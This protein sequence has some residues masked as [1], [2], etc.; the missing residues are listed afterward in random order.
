MR[1]GFFT[2]ALLLGCGA[3]TQPPGGPARASGMLLMN[4]TFGSAAIGAYAQSNVEGDF[5]AR[6]T[7]NNGLTEGRAVIV[8]E[9]GNRFL[10][11]TYV[12]GAFGPDA[13]GV[14]F[15]VALGASYDE[16]YFAYRVRFAPGFTFMRGGKLPGLVG[17]T[18]PTGCVSDIS[19]FSAR[20]MWRPGGAAVQYMYWPDKVSTCGDDFAYMDGGAAVTFVPGTW[21]EIEHRV[22]MNAPGRKNGVMQA[23]F[24]GRSV[25]DRSDFGYRVAGHSFGID[26]MYFSTFFGGSDATWAPATAQVADF[27]DFRTSTGPI[28][29]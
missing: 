6:A 4:A 12:G 17:G 9:A 19:G 23:W 8:E 13:G 27:D 26:A 22:V 25:L 10:R 16:M 28:T 11:V 24:D 3:S 29:H 18:A 5:G 1:V 2:V 7:W 21:H 14:Q 20:N 15:V